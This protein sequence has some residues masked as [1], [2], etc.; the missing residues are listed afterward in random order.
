MVDSLR[1]PSSRGH[2]LRPS[3]YGPIFALLVAI[4]VIAG[5][6]LAYNAILGRDDPKKAVVGFFEAMKR[7]N[8]SDLV[9]RITLPSE[10]RNLTEMSGHGLKEMAAQV[11]SMLPPGDVV[12]YEI[13]ESRPK[14]NLVR[15]TVKAWIVPS[16]TGP[17]YVTRDADGV[18]K[19][20]MIRTLQGVMSNS[21]KVGPGD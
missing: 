14:E 6:V 10:L 17:I 12:E 3:S 11:L 8:A 18:W 21:P 5:S 15:V 9:Q 1:E 19:V 13:L 2:S 16:Y 4:A 20:D 7:R